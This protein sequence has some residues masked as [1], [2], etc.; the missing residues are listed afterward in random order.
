MLLENIFQMKCKFNR[1][2]L[3]LNTL[4]QLYVA[5]ELKCHLLTV[6]SR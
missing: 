1:A 6:T 5:L 4:K 3:M 2:V